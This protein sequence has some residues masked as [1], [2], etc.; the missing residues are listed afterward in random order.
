MQLATTHQ[1]WPEL[2]IEVPHECGWMVP[3]R[4]HDLGYNFHVRWNS[5]GRVALEHVRQAV[6][7]LH[8]VSVGVVE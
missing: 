8:S 3:K 6:V 4:R 2:V 5:F 1:L 7:V